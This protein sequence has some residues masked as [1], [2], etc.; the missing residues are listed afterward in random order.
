MRQCAKECVKLKKPCDKTDCRLWIEY[1]K[2]L[3]CC[4][5]S[6]EESRTGKLTL[7]EAGERLGIS[8]VRVRQIEQKAIKKLSKIFLTF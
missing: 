1:E 2:D 3:N 7:H 4:L 6:I 5:I 8:F